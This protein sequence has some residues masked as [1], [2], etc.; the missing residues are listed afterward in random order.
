MRGE[1]IKTDSAPGAIGLYSQAVKAGQMI[2]C[3]GQIGIDPSTGNIVDSDV[4]NQAVQVMENLK[5]V[6]KAGGLSV[7]HIVKTTV[8][9]VSLDDYPVINEVY[10]EYFPEDPPARAAVGVSA[11][12]KGAKVEIEAIACE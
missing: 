10:R 3:S 9:L 7:D 4:K 2:F 1:V 8:Y 11:L 6:L 12:P 5:A